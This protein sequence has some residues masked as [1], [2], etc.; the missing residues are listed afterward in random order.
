MNPNS[1][2]S[3]SDHT[4]TS[5]PLPWVFHYQEEPRTGNSFLRDRPLLRP[6]VWVRLAKYEARTQVHRALVDSGADHILAPEWLA[7]QIGVDPDESRETKIRIGGQARMVRFANVTVHLC[8]PGM[9]PSTS[10]D[11]EAEDVAIEWEA[12]VGFFMHW[13]DPPWL[14]ILGQTGFF[15]RFTVTMSR[16]SQCVAIAPR[17]D[18]DQRFG[19]PPHMP[20][21]RPPRFTP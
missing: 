20:D 8:P 11:H 2:A 10:A 1:S 12:E 19:I 15:D 6:S 7:L 17:D 4:P 21:D 13:Q 14:V 16:L 18:F 3:G 5:R 9:D